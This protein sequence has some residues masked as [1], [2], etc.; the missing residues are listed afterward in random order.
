MVSQ[1]CRSFAC[2]QYR[3]GQKIVSTVFTKVSND[4]SEAYSPKREQ[5]VW[6]NLL[7]ITADMASTYSNVTGERVAKTALW[8][9]LG[10]LGLGSLA[11]ASGIAVVR[12]SMGLPVKIDL[13]E[14]DNKYVEAA[15]FGNG[16]FVPYGTR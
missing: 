1:T 3:A 11:L 8:S 6:P 7:N 12:Q 13:P 10:T 4:V 15:A 16:Y 14:T 2:S 9:R 5:G